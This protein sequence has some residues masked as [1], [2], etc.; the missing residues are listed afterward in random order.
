MLV[1]VLLAGLEPVPDIANRLNENRFPR[2][3]LDLGAQ[4]RHAAIHATGSYRDGIVPHAVQD[5]PAGSASVRDGPSLTPSLSRPS[6]VPRRS[7]TMARSDPN[8]G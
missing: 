6:I 5:I 4:R 1:E 2:V 8:S 3:R 7:K